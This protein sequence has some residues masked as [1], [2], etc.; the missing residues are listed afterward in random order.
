MTQTEVSESTFPNG[1]EAISKHI[2][3]LQTLKRCSGPRAFREALE[4]SQNE[5]GLLLGHYAACKSY[6]K[7]TIATWERIERSVRMPAKYA[8][9]DAARLAY[10]LLMA[11]VV[12]IAGEGRYQLK[13]K[14]G[15]RRWSFGLLAVCAQCGEWFPV[16]RITDKHCRRHVRRKAKR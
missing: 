3:L 12:T 9:T 5:M 8:M 15:K 7:S 2:G 14:M 1:L 4:V 11:D 10:R 16:R 6:S 13:A